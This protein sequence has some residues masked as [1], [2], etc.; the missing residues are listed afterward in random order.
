MTVT[1]HS[2]DVEELTEAERKRLAEETRSNVDANG[3]REGD[4]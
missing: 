1:D 3:D 4:A 2:I